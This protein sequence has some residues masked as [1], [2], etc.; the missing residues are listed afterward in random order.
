MIDGH[1][2]RAALIYI[3]ERGDRVVQTYAQLLHQVKQLRVGLHDA[4]AALVDVMSAALQPCPSI[5]CRSTAL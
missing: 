2:G 3:N 4:I 5:T 1:G